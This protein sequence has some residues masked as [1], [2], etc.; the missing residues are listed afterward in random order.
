[1]LGAG[2]APASPSV[3]NIALALSDGGLTRPRITE[4][5]LNARSVLRP[6]GAATGQTA[7]ELLK[8]SF[9]T[10]T[11]I[12]SGT[13]KHPGSG[14]IAAFAGIAFQKTHSAGGYF[15]YA[16]PRASAAM[17]ESGLVSVTPKP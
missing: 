17:P 2:L 6:L 13:F 9:M 14:R 4:G 10:D 1:M 8:A 5:S 15:L 7:A 3:A 11:G 12:M 16:P